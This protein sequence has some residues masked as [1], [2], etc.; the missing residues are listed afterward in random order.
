ML[1]RTGVFSGPPGSNSV[2]DPA[3][4]MHVVSH[5]IRPYGTVARLVRGKQ[6]AASTFSEG[7]RHHRIARAQR[8]SPPG[9]LIWLS[10]QW[11]LPRVGQ[12]QQCDDAVSLETLPQTLTLILTVTMTVTLTLVLTLSLTI[13]LTHWLESQ[14][15]V[16]DVEQAVDAALHRSRAVKW[17]SMR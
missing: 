6:T 3:Q 4:V 14:V 17:H 9:R 13:T 15:V 11:D 5:L 8:V 12:V 10:Q 7:H 1:V 16:E 2:E